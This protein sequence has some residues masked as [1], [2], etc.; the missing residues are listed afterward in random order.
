MLTSEPI[1]GAEVAGRSRRGLDAP[2]AAR[3]RAHEP[4]R[5]AAGPK[6]SRASRVGGV[7]EQY[8]STWPRPVHVA[9]ARLAVLD[10]HD[11][12][13]LGPAAVELPPMTTPPPTPVPSVSS[14][15][16]SAP[17]A[18]AERRAP[19]ARRRSRRCRRRPAG[20]TARAISARRSTSCERDVDR[21]ERAARALVDRERDA[22]ADRRDVGRRAARSTISIERGE[23]RL[24]RLVGVGVLDAFRSTRR[25]ASTTPGEDLRPAEIDSDDALAV[26][27]ARLPY[28]PGWR[29]KRSPT[30]STAADASRAR[31]RCRPAAAA[32][33]RARTGSRGRGDREARAGRDARWSWTPADRRRWLIVL[34]ASRS[35]GRSPATSSFRQ[36]R[37]RREQTARPAGARP[38][39]PSRTGCSSRHPT[40]ILLLG[41]D[42]GEHRPG[43][44]AT[45]TPTRSCSLH[46][47]PCSHRLAYLSI[48]RD[49]LVP[50]PGLGNAKINAAFQRGGAP[51]AIRTIASFTGLRSTTC[52]SST[53]TRFKDLIDDD[54]RHRRRCPEPI[55]SNKFDCPY[56]RG[57]CASLEGLALRKGTQ[58]MNGKRALIYS[59][60]RENQLDP[61]ESDITRGERQQA[62][63]RAVCTSCSASAPRSGCRSTARNCFSPSRRI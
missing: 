54:R 37:R 30:A 9:L 57:E 46:T 35:S 47:D 5:V 3:S 16:R 43:G 12:T 26:Q 24:L 21:A 8:D 40:T 22:E 44:P 28:F 31:F 56:R 34:L 36:R 42:H 19:R 32:P 14:T 27:A 1:A 20:R 49:L 48:P 23:Q 25:R 39:S 4:V 59:R 55:L 52:R 10:D 61:S 53:S 50:I 60:I 29:R 58:H 38:R 63:L 15:S 51:L 2:A 17:R 6:R 33:R 11:V 41:T 13:E 62:V 7:P 45:S 18:R